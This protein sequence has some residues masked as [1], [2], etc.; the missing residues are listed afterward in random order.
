[1]K[2]EN[3]LFRQADFIDTSIANLMA[4]LRDGAIL[5]IAIVYVFLISARSTA[6]TLIALPLS[7]LAAVLSLKAFGATINTMTLGAREP[8]KAGRAARIDDARRLFGDA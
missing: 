8:R 7:L 1:M 4:A 3:R 2:I 6:I 5:V